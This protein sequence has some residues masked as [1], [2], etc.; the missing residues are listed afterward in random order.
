MNLTRILVRERDGKFYYH[1]NVLRDD[2][3]HRVVDSP[4][5]YATAEEARQQGVHV[6][7][8]VSQGQP[9]KI[10]PDVLEGLEI[11]DLTLQVT[12]RPTSTYATVS[13][14]DS[15]VIIYAGYGA[16]PDK[17]FASPFLPHVVEYMAERLETLGMKVPEDWT[18]DVVV[19]DGD[20]HPVTL[21][22]EARDVH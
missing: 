9:Y 8:Y 15:K 20:D 19:V 13:T 22:A 14:P 1:I 3:D 17:Y 7:Q 10:L 16:I 6:V 5:G 18:P 2:N 11:S 21:P 12:A 4:M